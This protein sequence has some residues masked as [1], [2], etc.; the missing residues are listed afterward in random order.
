MRH[1]SECS[2]H[3]FNYQVPRPRESSVLWR[4][5]TASM[6]CGQIFASYPFEKLE[7]YSL[8]ECGELNCIKNLKRDYDAIKMQHAQR[9]EQI[10]Q[11]FL[12]S[13]AGHKNTFDVESARAAE[14]YNNHAVVRELQNIEMHY[15]KERLRV[16]DQQNKS[17]SEARSRFDNALLSAIGSN[18]RDYARLTPAHKAIY[19]QKL[20]DFQQAESS[21]R[22]TA[23]QQIDQINRLRNDR[24]QYLHTEEARVRQERTQSLAAAKG[25]YDA[26][27]GAFVQRKQAALQ[28]IQSALSNAADDC[29][30]RYPRLFADQRNQKLKKKTLSVSRE[31]LF[32]A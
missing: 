22:Q 29:D 28:P 26:S 13:S 20:R 14:G 31:G 10:E 4:Q 19:D 24:L 2:S 11:E 25:R 8:V 3:K 6:N 1:I 23:Y 12:A 32:F 7:K 15:T 30:A 9:I 17:I 27:I 18:H 16:Q 21:A 5:E